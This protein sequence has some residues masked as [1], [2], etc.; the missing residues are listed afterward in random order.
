MCAPMVVLAGILL[1]A[2]SGFSVVLPLAVCALMMV[3]MMRAMD[4]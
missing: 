2:G 4:H 3:V 1:G